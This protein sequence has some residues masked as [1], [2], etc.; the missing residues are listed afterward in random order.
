MIGRAALL[1]LALFFA[2]CG[3]TPTTPVLSNLTLEP[4]DGLH[5]GDQLH[6]TVVY[7]DPDGD[8]SGGTAEIA[9]RRESEPRGQLYPTPLGL[10]AA[11]RGL[12]KVE[13]QLPG[14]LIPGSYEI[15]VTVIDTAGRRSNPLIGMF[16]V[17]Q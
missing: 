9:L 8:L 7:S 12:L 5:P 16:T 4:T 1:A 2:G 17:A 14:A 13:I 11:V 15:A 10:N 3:S 6:L